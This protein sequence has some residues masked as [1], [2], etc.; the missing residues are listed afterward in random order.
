MYDDRGA[1]YEIPEWVVADPRDVV[2]DGDGDAAGA[3]EKDIVDA[4][5]DDEE[6]EDEDLKGAVAVSSSTEP[7]EPKGKQRAASPGAPLTLRARLSDRGSDVEVSIGSKQP[8]RFAIQQI[9]EKTGV[10]RVRLVYMGKPMD[11]ARTLAEGGWRTGQVVNAF[12]FEGD[13][14]VILRKAKGR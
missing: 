14:K 11:E 9:R 12:V 2:E 13:E 4:D 3:V 10:N 5:N 8:V 6:D 7:K 1:I